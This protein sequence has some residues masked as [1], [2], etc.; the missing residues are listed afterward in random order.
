MNCNQCQQ[1]LASD[2]NYRFC[3]YCGAQLDAGIAGTSVDAA[4]IDGDNT[5]PNESPF[6]KSETDDEKPAK[7]KKRSF[8]ETAWFMASKQPEELDDSTPENY[9]DIDR[10]TEPYEH[11]G[12]FPKPLRKEFSLSETA[13]LESPKGENKK[14]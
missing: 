11:T 10:M 1:D 4:A 7:K 9:T 14:K 8:S 13:Q 2:H 5:I 3:P 12:K 6:H